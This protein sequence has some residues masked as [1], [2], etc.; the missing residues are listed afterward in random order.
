[1]PTTV[2][3]VTK[4]HVLWVWVALCAVSTLLVFLLSTL[5]LVRQC[6]I[7]HESYKER[8]AMLNWTRWGAFGLTLVQIM[9]VMGYFT[10][11]SM[12]ARRSSN[13]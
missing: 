5:S 8:A 11:I 13:L 1:M 12:S 4:S 6:R 7:K 3:F 2:I 9:G 10:R